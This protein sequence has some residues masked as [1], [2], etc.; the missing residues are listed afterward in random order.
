MQVFRNWSRPKVKGTGAGRGDLPVRG[1]LPAA[2]AYDRER[3]AL[4]FAT[5]GKGERRVAAGAAP[6]NSGQFAII[7]ALPNAK[8]VPFAGKR[9]HRDFERERAPC[10]IDAAVTNMRI[11]WRAA[12]ARCS[13]PEMHNCRCPR[14]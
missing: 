2:G 1:A 13:A 4:S 8:Q 11:S 10:W 14:C 7:G 5:F 6:R 3:A 9:F 12:A